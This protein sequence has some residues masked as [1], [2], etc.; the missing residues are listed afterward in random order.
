MNWRSRQRELAEHGID[1]IEEPG[2]GMRVLGQRLWWN[3]MPHW[4]PARLEERRR[5]VRWVPAQSDYVT[6]RERQLAKIAVCFEEGMPVSKIAAKLGISRD[7]IYK[8][9]S[10][11]LSYEDDG[12]NHR[13]P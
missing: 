8:K 6:A 7:T 4:E 1:C 11:L 12:G 2:E 10:Y 9:L 13:T 5:R 3:A